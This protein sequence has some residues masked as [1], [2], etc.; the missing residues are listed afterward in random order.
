[1]ARPQVWMMPPQNGIEANV[2]A[3]GFWTID[4]AREWLQRM[5]ANLEPQAGGH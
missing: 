3:I 4:E 2:N 5:A 1:M